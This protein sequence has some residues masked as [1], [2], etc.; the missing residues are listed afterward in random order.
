MSSSRQTLSDKYTSLAAINKSR[1]GQVDKLPT[2]NKLNM[3]RRYL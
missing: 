3:I 2:S 1:P